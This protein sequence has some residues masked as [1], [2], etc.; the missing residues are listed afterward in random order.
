MSDHRV[1]TGQTPPDFTLTNTR[2]E[3]VTLSSFKGEKMFI[4][5]SIGV[6]PDR[7]AAGTWR[8]CAKTM[9]NSFSETPS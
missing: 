6:S 5:S 8:S 3:S 1:K 4:W 9:I 2:G 7:T